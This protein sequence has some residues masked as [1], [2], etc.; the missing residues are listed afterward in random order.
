VI[1]SPLGVWRARPLVL[2]ALL[3]ITS[4]LG[5]QPR[6]G[7]PSQKAAASFGGAIDEATQAMAARDYP[8]LR[9]SLRAALAF[10]PDDP[11]LLYQLA[12][13]EARTGDTAAALASLER[14]APQGAA[15]DV[16]ADSAFVAL[17][18]L[19]RFQAVVRRLAAGAAPVLRSDTAFTLSDP[20]F[21]PEGIAYD[22]VDDVFYVG[23]LQQRRIV[24][25]RRDGST[26]DFATS[27]QD[28]L[29]QVLGLRVDSARRRLWVATLAVDSAAPRFRRG[30][31]GWAAL[32]AYDLRDGRLAARYAAPDSTRPHLLNDVAIAPDSAVYVTD[33]EGDALYRLPVGG[34]ALERVHGGAP[35][36]SYPNGIAFDP[37]RPR[38]YVAH[39]E[40]ISVIDVAADGAPRVARMVAPAGVG[41]GGVDGLYACRGGLLAVQSLLDFQQVT[42]FALST[43]GRGITSAR[44]LERR[45]PAHDAATTGALAGTELY[46][47]ANA[48]LDR[49]LD[50]GGVAPAAEP[51]RSVILRLPVDVSCAGPTRRAAG[52]EKAPIRGQTT[53]RSAIS[54]QEQRGRF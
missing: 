41:T 44:A 31:G 12:R 20:D 46:Y 14:L 27:G 4:P 51:H 15:R 33:S 39:I 49:L 47:I 23:S 29:G 11:R 28:G 21:I 9:R 34:S 36:F 26:S 22:P 52:A 24:R 7:Q 35:A 5:A 43:D 1:G 18:A 50:G 37:G 45:H 17:R 8:A 16:A 3:A 54:D 30:V 13:A 25:V 40:G 42:H 10:A 38:L 48:Q 53:G 19:P 32:H 2:A 6:P